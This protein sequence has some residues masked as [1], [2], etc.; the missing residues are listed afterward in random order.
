M[1]HGITA[2]R[3]CHILSVSASTLYYIPAPD[4]NHEL[5]RRLRAVARPGIG[6]RL[7]RALTYRRGKASSAPSIPSAFIASGNKSIW[8]ASKPARSD[9]PEPPCLWLPHVPIKF[10]VWIFVMML[11]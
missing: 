4:R 2:R 11:V 7:A 1:E 5:R 8:R 3:A 10:G 9:A 6:Y